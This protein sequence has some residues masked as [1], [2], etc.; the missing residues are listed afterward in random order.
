MLTATMRHDSKIPAD[1]VR[2]LI[3]FLAQMEQVT[4]RALV[5]EPPVLGK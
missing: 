5:P 1:I 3:A 2:N 4:S